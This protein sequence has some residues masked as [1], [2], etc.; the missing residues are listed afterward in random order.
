MAEELSLA[1]LLNEVARLRASAGRTYPQQPV[2]DQALRSLELSVE[3]LQVASEE[4][5]VKNEELMLALADRDGEH[6]RYRDLFDHAVDGYVVTNA[7]DVVVEANRAAGELAGRPAESLIGCRLVP[8]FTA[9]SRQDA[10]RMARQARSGQR[11]EA[12][13]TLASPEP[14]GCLVHVRYRRLGEARSAQTHWTLTDLERPMFESEAAAEDDGSLA[15]RW[16][17]IYGELVAVTE[18]L[19]DSVGDRADTMSREARQHFLEIQLRP[20][21]ARLGRL[22]RRRDHWSQRHAELVGFELDSEK[23]ELHYRDRA[24]DVTRR[25]RQLLRFLLE[26]PGTFFPS[27]VLLVRAWQASYLSEEQ[28][29]TYVARLRRKLEHLDLPCELVTRRPHGYALIFR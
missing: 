5:Q 7:D 6:R 21:E 4:L 17:G 10:V 26:R 19:R 27:R 15:R 1:P 23:N 16:L 20:V 22:R 13:L 24:V 12:V 14:A 28:V 29:R 2:L 18:S 3:E 9:A 11:G 8:L 25:E